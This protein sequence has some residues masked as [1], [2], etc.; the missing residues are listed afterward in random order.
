MRRQAIKALPVVD[1]QRQVLG[2]ITV[3]DFMRLAHLETHEGLG[4][5]LRALILGRPR[6]PDRV[7]DLMSSPAQRVWGKTAAQSAGSWTSQ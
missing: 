4:R 2:I 7:E 3:A 1:A 6:Q 5:R